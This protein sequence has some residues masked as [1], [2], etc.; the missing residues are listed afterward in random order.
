MCSCLV[1]VFCC[2]WALPPSLLGSAASCWGAILLSSQVNI[3]RC[4]QVISSTWTR[5]CAPCHLLMP[6]VAGAVFLAPGLD[7]TA[8]TETSRVV[9]ILAC[10]ASLLCR[11]GACARDTHACALLEY[12]Q[13]SHEK[14]TLL[15]KRQL[16]ISPVL[17]L[18]AFS[19][20]LSDLIFALA[21][22]VSHSLILSHRGT[23]HSQSAAMLHHDRPH[24]G[25]PFSAHLGDKPVH[26]ALAR[27]WKPCRTLLTCACI[28]RRRASTSDAQLPGSPCRSFVDRHADWVGP[29]QL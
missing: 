15:V 6:S 25:R 22:R 9:Y 3:A 7:H 11:E 13:T 5:C 14:Q 26:F 16:R 21:P 20:H 18:T 12:V 29:E 27:Q 23:K 24:G 19:V 4:V 10:R 17:M 8:G 1:L 2:V 28:L